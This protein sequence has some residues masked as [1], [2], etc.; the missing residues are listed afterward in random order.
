MAKD[1]ILPVDDEAR[2]LAKKLMR[3]VRSGALATNDAESG[4]PFASLVQVGTDLDGSP[5]IL[6]SQLSMHTRLLEADPLCSLLLSSV[7]KGDPLAHP[8]LTLLAKAYRLER[9]SSDTQ[10]IRRRYLL[11]HPKAELY[12]DFPDFAFWRLGVVSASLNGGFGRAYR[13][14]REDLLAD[15]SGFFDFYDFE[16]QAIDHMNE[17]HADAVALYATQLCGAREGAWRLIGIDPE[18]VQMTLGDE[19]LRLPFPRALT[20]PH[21]VRPMLIALAQEA[22][23]RTS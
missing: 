7:G 4:I 10:Q 22:R 9:E 23:A 19:I 16:A 8:R 17:D 5:L 15:L 2:A 12:V 3:T 6:T 18:G 20:G 13:M 14:A 1:P 21:E 11:Q